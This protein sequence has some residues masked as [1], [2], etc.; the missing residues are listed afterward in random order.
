VHRQ[1]VVPP[2]LLGQ[3]HAEIEKLCHPGTL[4]VLPYSGPMRRVVKLGDCRSIEEDRPPTWAEACGPGSKTIMAPCEDGDDPRRFLA[5]VV[6]DKGDGVVAVDIKFEKELQ[7]EKNVVITTYDTLRQCSAVLKKIRWYRIV[8]DECQ[9]IRTATSRIAQMCAGLQ[10]THRFMVSGTPLSA[11][12]DDLH[13]ELNFLNVSETGLPVLVLV[14]TCPGLSP[15]R[16]RRSG[17]SVSR[18]TVFG[19]RRFQSPSPARRRRHSS[20]FTS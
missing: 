11:S 12:I 1:I 16:F 6:Q 15:L 4:T 8:L 20:Y 17:P 13:G 2:S 7:E 19:R 18:M 5:K 14:T 9:E 10:A 3:W